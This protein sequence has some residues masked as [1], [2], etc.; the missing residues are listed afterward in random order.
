[1][2]F[3]AQFFI[4]DPIRDSLVPPTTLFSNFLLACPADSR[5]P[6]DW[7]TAAARRPRH[8]SCRVGARPRSRTTLHLHR[9]PGGPLE[10]CALSARRPSL[11]ARTRARALP[12]QNLPQDRLANGEL[13]SSRT[14]P[15]G[16]LWLIELLGIRLNIFTCSLLALSGL[17]IMSTEYTRDILSTKHENFRVENSVM[18]HHLGTI[19]I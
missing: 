15:L 6:R 1:M 13:H 17:W 3:C 5:R 9:A 14:L 11:A 8:V 19:H 12:L 16:Y 4:C 18:F 7:R 10:S 2:C